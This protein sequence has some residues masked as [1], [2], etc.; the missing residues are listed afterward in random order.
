MILRHL[1]ILTIILTVTCSCTNNETNNDSIRDMIEV[2]ISAQQSEIETRTEI[3]P[4]DWA[5]INWLA[6]DKIQL[7]ATPDGGASYSLQN[8]TFSLRKHGAAL[9]EAIF[10]ATIPEMPQVQHDYYAAYPEPTTAS[11]T[12]LKYTIPTTQTGK[13]VGEND[14]MVSHPISGAGLS[15]TQ[16]SDQGEYIPLHFRHL[17]HLMRISIPSGRNILGEPISKLIIN[18]PTNVGGEFEFDLK[19]INSTAKLTNGSRTITVEFGTPI[20]DDGQYIWVFTA[21]TTRIVGDLEFIAV[22]ETGKVSELISKRIDKTFASGRVTPITLTIPKE[23]PLTTVSFRLTGSNLGEKI[24]SLTAIAPSGA[25]FANGRSQVTVNDQMNGS[26]PHGYFSIQYYA[27]LYGTAMKE[28]DLEVRYESENTLTQEMF[29]LSGI[30][31]NT[32]AGNF[33]S[34]FIPYLFEEDFSN[35]KGHTGNEWTDGE[36]NNVGLIGW[37]GSDWITHANSRLQLSSYYNNI[38]NTANCDNGRV[39]TAP[40]AKIKQG[41]QVKLRVSYDV[42]GSFSAD[43]GAGWKNGVSTC[44]FGVTN[45]MDIQPG[46]DNTS[47]QRP[48]AIIT[49][50]YDL[51]GN[52][53]TKTATVNAATAQTRLSWAVYKRNWGTIIVLNWYFHMYIDNIK[54]QITQ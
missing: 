47:P 32:H 8:A 27:I 5:R 41:K 29:N 43:W 23:A 7:W 10:T 38:L 12:L 52:P 30:T 45:K 21:P 49:D 42:S 31:E 33:Y 26:F 14:I 19:D 6:E 48:E 18:F 11:G 40:L 36:M 35:V 28:S 39:N 4:T 46:G 2:S 13:Y 24:N 3:D 17:T 51:T 53:T 44:S 15:P 54:V 22:S 1:A 50:W 9:S 37:S 16:G 20:V 34:R 25:A